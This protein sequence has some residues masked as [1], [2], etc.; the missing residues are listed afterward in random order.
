[1]NHVLKFRNGLKR[2][3]ADTDF[4]E[5]VVLTRLTV[6]VVTIVIPS[7][8]ETRIIKVCRDV[9]A[10]LVT[11]TR[12]H[13]AIEST[14]RDNIDVAT[15]NNHQNTVVLVFLDDVV[16]NLILVVIASHISVNV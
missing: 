6:T 10:F 12:C 15:Q 5:E 1:M 2:H 14:V 9:V 3:T 4:R 16:T 7:A 11:T 13:I 8:V